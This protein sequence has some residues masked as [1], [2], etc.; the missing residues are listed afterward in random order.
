M[1]NAN[2]I[3]M[4]AL[5]LTQ[6]GICRAADSQGSLTAKINLQGPGAISDRANKANSSQ[7]SGFDNPFYSSTMSGMGNMIQGMT[8]NNSNIYSVQE[9]QRQQCDYAKQQS[10]N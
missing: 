8:G 10:G 7:T 2:L 6:V 4:L 9:S 5:A 3:L 1:R